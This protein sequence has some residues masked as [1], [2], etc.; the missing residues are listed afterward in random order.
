MTNSGT[1]KF[2]EGVTPSVGKLYQ[3]AT[4][5][6]LIE[7]VPTKAINANIFN[8]KTNARKGKNSRFGSKTTLSLHKT[9]NCSVITTKSSG[10]FE[11]I[12]WRQNN[13]AS[14]LKF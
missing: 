3:R 4:Y 11:H 8:S 12:V 6:G 5:Y 13:F 14:S 2:N 1:L 10:L 9:T 7:G